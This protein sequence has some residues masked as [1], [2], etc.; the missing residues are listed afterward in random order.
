M[1]ANA[2]IPIS[3]RVPPEAEADPAAM[4][5][6][7]I[8]IREQMRALQEQ[9]QELQHLVRRLVDKEA[10]RAAPAKFRRGADGGT[11]IWAGEGT[12]WI[13][14]DGTVDESQLHPRKL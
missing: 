3:M 8:F 7:L 4:Y 9:N 5:Q 6:V 13:S 14:Y 12:G 1:P 2:A 10:A 11:Q